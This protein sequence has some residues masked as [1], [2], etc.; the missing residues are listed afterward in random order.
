VIITKGT[1]KEN[2]PF[3]GDDVLYSRKLYANAKHDK[4]VGSAVFTCFYLFEKR[5][6]C[7][8]YFDL[9]G[10]MVLASGRV[11]Y[12]SSRYTLSVTGGTG[13]YLGVR[14]TVR[15]APARNAQLLELRLSV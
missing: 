1:Q 9:K 14:G 2:G 8:A 13:D 11:P 6:V 10:G 4:Q 15:A 12:N 7:H 3:P 5:A